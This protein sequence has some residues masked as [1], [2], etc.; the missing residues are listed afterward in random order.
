MVPNNPDLRQVGEVIQS[1]AAEAGFDAEAA[2]TEFASSLQAAEHGEFQTYLVGWSGRTDPDGNIYT[3]I[4]LRAPQND[5]GYCDPEVDACSTPRALERR[6]SA[7]RKNALRPGLR[8]MS[9]TEGRRSIYLWHRKN[10]V[11]HTDAARRLPCRCPT[12]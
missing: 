7:E 1:M 9:L 11:A 10:M 12:A 8:R 5:G 4:R 6:T 3:F 2:R